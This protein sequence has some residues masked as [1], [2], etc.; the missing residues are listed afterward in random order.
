MRS[1]PGRRMAE[2]ELPA[3]MS[4]RPSVSEE[5]VSAPASFQS[6]DRC[7]A[8]YNH[9]QDLGI[10]MEPVLA[11]P[12]PHPVL[13]ASDG[14]SLRTS[15]SGQHVLGSHYLLHETG[16]PIVKGCRPA[17]LEA[18]DFCC[19]CTWIVPLPPLGQ[20]R[21][22][23]EKCRDRQR[24]SPLAHHIVLPK[25]R[26]QGNIRANVR[27]GSKAVMAVMGWKRTFAAADRVFPDCAVNV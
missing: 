27:H 18:F 22:A 6:R 2:D 26:T 3:S 21:T 17:F 7:V 14:R 20:G 23:Q 11:E 16:V 8:Y 4:P 5:G 1:A 12:N 15:R 9:I 25:S 19:G 10:V 13:P 24:Y